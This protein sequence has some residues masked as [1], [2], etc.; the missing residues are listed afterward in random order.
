VGDGKQPPL[1]TSVHVC[2]CWREVVVVVDCGLVWAGSYPPLAAT[3]PS[4]KEKMKKNCEAYHCAHS[5]CPQQRRC[6]QGSKREGSHTSPIFTLKV[7]R[8][9]HD[10]SLGC[11]ITISERKKKN[12]GHTLCPLSNRT[13]YVGTPLRPLSSLS[14]SVSMS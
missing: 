10:P 8:G 5:H 9:G 7:R 14:P 6:D 11:H 13:M 4:A 1:K 3:S 2:S 12:R